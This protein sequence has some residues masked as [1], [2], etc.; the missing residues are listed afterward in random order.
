MNLK[1]FNES[2]RKY[3]TEDIDEVVTESFESDFS[4]IRFKFALEIN[5]SSDL[6]SSKM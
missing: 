1:T 6:N 5:V 2:F 4:S 3:Y